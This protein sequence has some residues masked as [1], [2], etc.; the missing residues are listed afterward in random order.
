MP[1][2]RAQERESE[3]MERRCEEVVTPGSSGE[4]RE[5]GGRL[6]VSLELLSR[7]FRRRLTRLEPHL[8]G[9]IHSCSCSIHFG[10]GALIG[11][12]EI[13]QATALGAVGVF[14]I[15]T[16]GSLPRDNS[17]GND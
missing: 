15:W 12:E 7:A 9:I 6:L 16:D 4:R 11:H 14:A 17:S 1:R 3:K 10:R 2:G 5:G 8:T 13:Y